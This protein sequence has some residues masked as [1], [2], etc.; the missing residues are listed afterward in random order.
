MVG[1]RATPEAIEDALA[2]ARSFNVVP[3]TP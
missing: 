1:D 2:A 3:R